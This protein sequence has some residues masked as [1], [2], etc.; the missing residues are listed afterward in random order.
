MKSVVRNLTAATIILPKSL[1]SFPLPAAADQ[2]FMYS[3]LSTPDLKELTD[4]AVAGSISFPG[5]TGLGIPAGFQVT[6]S[7]TYVLNGQEPDNVPAGAPGYYSINDS[8]ARVYN[9]YQWTTDKFSNWAQLQRR[10]GQ[11][12][13]SAQVQFPDGRIMLIGGLV[14]G[15][16]PTT[17]CQLYTPSTGQWALAAALP[18]AKFS[19]F[20]CVL[21]DGNV[22][23][24]GGGATLGATDVITVNTSYIYYPGTGPGI[25]DHWEA[26]AAMPQAAAT[27]R[28]TTP[29]MRI[30]VGANAGKVLIAGG[31]RNDTGDNAGVRVLKKAYL[32][33]PGPGATPHIGSSWAA[34]GDMSRY[35]RDLVAV[36]MLDGNIAYV[37]GSENTVV[38]G[39][40]IGANLRPYHGLNRIQ[41]Y[42]VTAGTF[43]DSAVMPNPADVPG[44]K[45]DADSA[46]AADTAGGRWLHAALRLGDGRIAV[47]GGQNGDI[48][49]NGSFT[50][51]T[52]R[53]SVVV[54]T[55]GSNTWAEFSGMR[56]ERI[57]PHYA[58]MNLSGGEVLLLVGGEGGGNS[59]TASCEVFSPAL[60]VGSQN[61]WQFTSRYTHAMSTDF[62]SPAGRKMPKLVEQPV[63]LLPANRTVPIYTP[64][65]V[66]RNANG[67]AATPT[68]DHAAS[69]TAAR[70]ADET[71]G[72]IVD[73]A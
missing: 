56:S 28:T 26:A 10:F 8:A 39:D 57:S 23:A 68:F 38:N 6:P 15:V 46:Y 29:G 71:V 48:A 7:L 37:G 25:D 51:F 53:R 19:A 11:Q 52:S 59:Q 47:I 67:N 63:A 69:K 54:Y 64:G 50:L 12:G 4:L 42:D 72:G 27:R 65:L 21:A 73:E 5:S 18:V 36:E 33:T 40:A 20:V 34:T 62:I 16:T 49:A 60:G 32:F 14:G 35:C 13:A 44:D 31:H 9:G 22:L 45:G 61:Q 30:T 2:D 3:G 41:I 24:C 55:P 66:P 70:L 1:N 58:L 43:S 17:Q